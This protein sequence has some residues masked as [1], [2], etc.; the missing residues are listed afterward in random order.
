MGLKNFL[1]KF[2]SGRRESRP[3]A[4][5]STRPEQQVKAGPAPEQTRGL[6]IRKD[7]TMGEIL[8]LYPGAQR[9][10]FQKFHI[11]GCSSCGFEESDTLEQVC[12]SHNILSVDEAIEQIVA[13]YVLDKQLQIE[14]KDA[15]ALVKSNP[16]VKLID[17]REPF[18]RNLAYIEGSELLS[19]ELAQEIVTSWPKD[20]PIIFYCHHGIRSLD[21]ASYFRGHGF[22]NVKSMRGG[23]DSWSREV[24]PSVRRY[25]L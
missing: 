5:V 8:R 14:P 9:A 23:I 17:V 15:A 21:A 16:Q 3:A 4:A 20:T 11:G 18:E 7:M 10:L 22:T 6:S 1:S 12:R 24:D 19:V 2:S 25:R 13:S